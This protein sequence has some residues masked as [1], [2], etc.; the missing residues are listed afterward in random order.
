MT[1]E[2]QMIEAVID[3]FNNYCLMIDYKKISIILKSSN[4]R[5]VVLEQTIIE[6]SFNQSSIVHC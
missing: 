5:L 4:I 1:F 6:W 3:F 2:N